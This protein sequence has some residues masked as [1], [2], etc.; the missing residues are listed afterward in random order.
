MFIFSNTNCII[1]IRISTI[2]ENLLVRKEQWWKWRICSGSFPGN[3]LSGL[4]IIRS[5]II[6]SDHQGQ[7]IVWVWVLSRWPTWNLPGCL[8]GTLIGAETRPDWRQRVFSFLQIS[9]EERFLGLC[10]QFEV[11]FDIMYVHCTQTHAQTHRH[12]LC[13]KFW[14]VINLT[15]LNPGG[16]SR[17]LLRRCQGQLSADPGRHQS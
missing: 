8:I 1:L 5:P 9:F 2:Q 14:K 10:K 6:K 3:Q 17:S 13:W 4:S 12:T 15:T 16:C 11:H 7:I